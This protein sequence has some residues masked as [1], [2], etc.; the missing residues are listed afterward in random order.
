MSVVPTKCLLYPPNVSCTHP[1]NIQ[2]RPTITLYVYTCRVFIFVPLCE[3]NRTPNS[4]LLI[5]PLWPPGGITQKNLRSAVTPYVECSYLVLTHLCDVHTKFWSAR[6]N[7]FMYS[8]D[9]VLQCQDKH[10]THFTWGGGR[11]GVHSE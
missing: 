5:L 9:G 11:A 8:F 6:K 3:L 10:Q 1:K 4:I 7:G 2:S